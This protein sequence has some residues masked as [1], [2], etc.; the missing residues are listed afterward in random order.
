MALSI[1]GAGFGRTGTL[2]LKSALETLGFDKCYH[3]SEVFVTPGHAQVWHAAARGEPVD[4]DALFE[5]YQAAVDWPA[6]SFW[7][8]LMDHY[9]ESK[10]LLSLRDPEKWFDSA[11]ETIFRGMRGEATIAGADEPL[12]RELGAMAMTLIRDG[13]FGGDVSDRENAIRVF[14]EHNEAVRAAVPPDRL[15][16]YQASEGWEPLCA[17]LDRPVPDEPFPRVNS[18]EDFAVRRF[19]QGTAGKP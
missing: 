6:C 3:M 12:V 15:L 9:P 4:W 13:T 16:V 19:M 17:F 14:N 11:N 10:V 7:R 2:S 8:E 18:R 5:G 1:V